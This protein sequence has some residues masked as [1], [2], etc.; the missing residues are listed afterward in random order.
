MQEIMLKI[1]HQSLYELSPLIDTSLVHFLLSFE[2]CD[3]LFS[4]KYQLATI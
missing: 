2:Y 3:G 1:A 4:F